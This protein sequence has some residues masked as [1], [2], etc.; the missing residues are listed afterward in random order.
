MKNSSYSYYELTL[1]GNLFQEWSEFKKG[2][3]KKLDVQIFSNI[4]FN[5]MDQ[6][7]KH[8]LKIKYYVR[9][10][11]DFIIVSKDRS[12]LYSCIDTSQ[13][14]LNN[15]LKLDLHPNK[16]LIRKLSWGIDFLGY[17]VL[18]YYILPRTKNRERILRRLEEKYDSDNFNQT[19]ESYLGYLSHSNSYYFKEEMLSRFRV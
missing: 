13:Q 7:M 5:E 3:R 9:Y 11:D 17:I 15:S 12:F 1:I 18:P 8:K 4:Y 10:A 14:F 6:F 16:I 19:L 2:K